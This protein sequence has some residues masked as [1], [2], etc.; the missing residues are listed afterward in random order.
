MNFHIL[1]FPWE[2]IG[3]GLR[4]LSLSGA[5]GNVLAIVLFLLIGLL[6]CGAFVLLKK[7][8]KALPIDWMLVVLTVVLFWVLYYMI[9]PGLLPV[10][11]VSGKMLLGSAFYSVL[12]GYVVIR[13]ISGNKYA[14]VIALQKALRIVLYVVMVLFA[15]SV[16]AELFINLPAAI[17]VV[18][19]GN[20]AMGM[21]SNFLYDV[22]DLTMTYVFLILQSVVNALPNALCGI[23]VLLCIRVLDELLR[24]AYSQQAQTLVKR[25]LRF[26]KKSLV[27]VVVSGM[28]LNLMQIAL[29]HTLYQVNVEV[30]IPIFSIL[31]FLVIHLIARYIEENQKLKLDNDLFI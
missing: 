3:W 22:P 18:K 14:D 8:G 15:W 27:V 7:K 31:F 13:V 28:V 19:E 12:I 26:C 23:V 11:M 4:Q 10:A 9:N 17:E 6:P 21:P 20:A 2:Q 24:D 16:V 30:N 29:A 5:G 1:N 25:I